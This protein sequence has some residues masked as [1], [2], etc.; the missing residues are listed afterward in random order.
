MKIRFGR[1]QFG[2]LLGISERQLTEAD[3]R[4]ELAGLGGAPDSYGLRHLS[5]YRG[6]L[7][8]HPPVAE[9]RHQLSLNFKGGTGKTSIRVA[10]ASRRA[11]MGHRVR[12]I[13]LDSQG[14]ATQH[15]GFEG[16]E[17]E[18][19]LYDTLVN[20]VPL[21]DVILRTPLSEFDVIPA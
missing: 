16:D 1:R 4:P 2:K 3:Q 18:R 10:Y 14:H 21:E 5:A 11:E 6:A 12:R 17:C 7:D 9:P 8:L 13:D 20:E 19:T 15:L